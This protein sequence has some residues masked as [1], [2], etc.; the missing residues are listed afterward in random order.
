MPR[1][2][3][4]RIAIATV[5]AAAL[6]GP[7]ATSH[8]APA[9]AHVALG[10]VARAAQQDCAGADLTP[11]ARNEDDVRA[12]ILCL[13]NRIRAERGREEAHAQQDGKEDEYPASEHC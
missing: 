5:L 11:T 2:R 6:L 8:A 3:S 10:P 13:H 9:R 12:A 7:A 4:R 1:K